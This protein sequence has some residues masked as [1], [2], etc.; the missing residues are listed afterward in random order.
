MAGDFLFAYVSF[1]KTLLKLNRQQ[2]LIGNQN[3]VALYKL[4]KNECI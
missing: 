3:C 4:K 1:V 2:E